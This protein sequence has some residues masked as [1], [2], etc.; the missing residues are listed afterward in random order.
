MRAR[1]I[2]MFKH[3]LLIVAI[4]T[5]VA[6]VQGR[7][8]PDNVGLIWSTIGLFIIAFAVMSTIGTWGAT[9]NFTYQY[10]LTMEKS[11]IENWEDNNREMR[12]AFQFLSSSFGIGF[13]AIFAGLVTMVVGG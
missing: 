11:I 3:Q 13:V 8:R 10:G 9:R 1:L 6:A 2:L 12:G 7:I 4:A 5:A